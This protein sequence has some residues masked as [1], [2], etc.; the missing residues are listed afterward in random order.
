MGF[1][2]LRLVFAL[3]DWSVSASLDLRRLSRVQLLPHDTNMLRTNQFCNKYIFGQVANLE[4]GTE[5]VNF[6]GIIFGKI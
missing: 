6:D 5:T 2:K 4:L 1:T 3:G